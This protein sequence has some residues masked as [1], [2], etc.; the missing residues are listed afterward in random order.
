VT[1][2]N[3]LFNDS[4]RSNIVCGRRGFS[5]ETI[6]AAASAAD[7]EDFIMGLP[8]RYDTI[9]GEGGIKLSGG[10]RQRLAIARAVLAKPPVLILD[11]ATSN[12]DPESEARVQKA[13]ADFL[14]GA[15]VLIIAHRL[16]AIRRADAIAVLENGRIS[17]AGSHEELFAANG[18]YRR[19]VE[20]QDI[21]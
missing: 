6:A 13:L 7:A 3:L 18:S 16:A 10:Q 15:T 20:M 8:D 12:L 4:I 17:E 21:S 11:E 19:M 9:I 2:E 14:P 5:D 1:Q